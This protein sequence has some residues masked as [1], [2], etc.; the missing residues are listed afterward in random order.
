MRLPLRRRRW[1]REL[2]DATAPFAKSEFARATPGPA[3][4]FGEFSAAT[5]LGHAAA[6]NLDI[7]R[8]RHSAVKVI[9]ITPYRSERT[10]RPLRLGRFENVYFLCQPDTYG[11]VCRLIEP[12]EIAD[13]WR[14]GRL[15]WETPHFPE[16]W[17][18]VE[19]FLHEAW[20]PS[21]FC[22]RAFNNFLELRVRVVPHA[23]KA[24]PDPGIDMRARFGVPPDAFMGL[25][26]MDIVSCPAR[27][28]PWEHVRACATPSTTATNT[29]W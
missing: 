25:A 2:V 1:A 14:I 27:K 26:I 15:V 5:G 11:L 12:R 3:L 28:N 4:V 22:V 18:F 23:V 9:D 13:A 20:A 8:R 16:S 24:P 7:L 29:C 6:Y 21:R 19:R 17:R 10:P